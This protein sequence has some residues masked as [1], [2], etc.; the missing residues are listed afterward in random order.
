MSEE[1]EEENPLEIQNTELPILELEKQVEEM[2]IK[3]RDK[4]A[5]M[6]KK[7]SSRE[8]MLIRDGGNSKQG[9]ERSESKR[10]N[11]NLGMKKF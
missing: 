11:N 3:N 6:S 1:A 9:D 10:S 4:S 8:I 2:I 5:N 7:N